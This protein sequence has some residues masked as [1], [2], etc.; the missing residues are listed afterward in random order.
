MKK[1]IKKIVSVLIII[2]IV[3]S[4]QISVYSHSG[5]TD[6]NGGHKDNQ[7]KSGLGSYHYHCGGYPA[8]LHTNGVCPYSSS[9]KSN[10]NSS[11]SSSNSNS[12]TKTTTTKPTTVAVT[13]IQ[14]NEN[15][16]TLE[17]GNNKILTATITPDNAT[18]KSITWKSSDESIATIS[19]TGELIAKKPGIVD[20]TVASS[21]GKTSSIKINIKE[22]P[23]TNNMITKTSTNVQNNIISNTSTKNKEDSNP[24]GGVL[25]LGILVGGGYAGYKHYKNKK[26]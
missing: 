14:I 10:K 23:K 21:N 12:N 2:L 22:T 3:L 8:H 26:K 4:M 17:V 19:T 5:R 25:V 11:S 18:D 13:G 6:A 16:E 15:I 9:S 1:Y 7:N 24:I 20:I